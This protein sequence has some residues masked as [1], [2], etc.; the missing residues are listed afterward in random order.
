[1]IDKLFFI[2]YQSLGDTF[3]HNGIAHHYAK[4]CKELHVPTHPYYEGTTR[5]LYQDFPN[6][7]VVSLMPGEEEERYVYDNRMSRLQ[8]DRLVYV[9]NVE[10]RSISICF[11]MQYYAMHDVPFS[12]RYR[13]FRLPKHVEG[14]DELYDRLVQNNEPYVLFHRKVNAAPDG[15]PVDIARFRE[16]YNLPKIKVIEVDRDIDQGN[17]LRWVKLIRNATEIHVVNGSFWNLV[18]SML[19]QTKAALYFHDIRHPIFRINHEWN[20][21]RWTVVGYPERFIDESLYK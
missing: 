9:D 3:I 19:D 20:N 1:M 6:I 11:D 10:K 15:L 7:K 17:M 18:E 8:R 12:E 14:A 4:M 5:C 16:H 13:G 21:Y 2:G